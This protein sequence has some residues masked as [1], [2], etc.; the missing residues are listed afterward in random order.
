[1]S[2]TGIVTAEGLFEV[3]QEGDTLIVV[4]AVDLRELDYQRIKAGAKTVLDL[5]NGTGVRNVV[6]DFHK[7]DCYGS[8][9]LGFFLRPLERVRGQNGRTALCNVSG[10]EKEILQITDLDHTWPIYSSRAEALQ[11][12]KKG[13]L[14]EGAA[15]AG[16]EA[17][18][19]ADVIS[20]LWRHGQRTG[21]RRSA[22]DT[23]HAAPP[24]T[25]HPLTDKVQ[26]LWR[27]QVARLG[28]RWPQGSGTDRGPHE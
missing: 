11:A 13:G 15:M 23:A 26:R 27:E 18:D 14:G 7:T 21:T 2:Q 3:E 10:H 5:L 16:E 17:V 12:V 25:P 22:R 9:A 6:V 24:E 20:L 28:R 1:M 8:A 19:L 4:P